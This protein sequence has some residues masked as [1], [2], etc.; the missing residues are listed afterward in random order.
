MDSP[1]LPGN[2]LLDLSC[3]VAL[4]STLCGPRARFQA[5]EVP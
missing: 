2:E 4:L 1:L 3:T 5:L